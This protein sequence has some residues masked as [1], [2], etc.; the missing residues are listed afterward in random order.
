[1]LQRESFK[2]DVPAPDSH[3]RVVNR[4]FGATFCPRPNSNQRR[5]TEAPTL[6]RI[7]V[8][9]FRLRQSASRGHALLIGFERLRLL[10]ERVPKGED[11]LRESEDGEARLGFEG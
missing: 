9:W 7:R 4:S 2:W 3:H 5:S 11:R 6:M 10:E 8:N 1:M